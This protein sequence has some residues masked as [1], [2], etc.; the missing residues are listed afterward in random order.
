[1]PLRDDCRHI[2]LSYLGCSPVHK[3]VDE[4]SLFIANN[5]SSP[6]VWLQTQGPQ[7]KVLKTTKFAFKT[8]LMPKWWGYQFYLDKIQTRV[9]A[10]RAGNISHGGS[11]SSWVLNLTCSHFSYN[12][13]LEIA[14]GWLIKST[15]SR[16]FG[17]NFV[18]EK[19]QYLCHYICL[20]SIY[21]FWAISVIW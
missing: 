8:H 10:F 5:H 19:Y 13:V 4:I 17:L 20:T 16:L 3:V 21:H 11:L 14:R 1:M 12:T 6:L 9:L 2:F 18:P 7:C 15:F